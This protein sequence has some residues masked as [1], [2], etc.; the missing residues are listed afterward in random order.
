MY[1][2]MSCLSTSF[3]DGVLTV[4]I[5]NPPLNFVGASFIN[6]LVALLDALEQRQDCN[7]VVFKSDDPDFFLSRADITN[8]ADYTAAASKSGGPGDNFLG[9]LLRRVADTKAITIAQI[10]GRTRGAGSE[11]ALACDM[12]FASKEHA[13]FG[14]PEAGVGLMPGSGAVQHLT[15]LMGRGRALEV[16]LS[17]NDYSADEAVEYGWINKALPASQ[18]ETY[19]IQLAKRIAKFSRQGLLTIKERVNAIALP[20]IDAVRSDAAIFQALARSPEC[21][22]RIGMIRKIGLDTRGDTELNFGRV[23]GEI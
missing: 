1:P 17:S 5:K 22:D 11:F 23:L 14:Q 8:V 4:S 19:V 13:V 2:E 18:L 16:L 6:D 3:S 9:T 7:V 10:E 12:R 20:T 21:Q 15:R